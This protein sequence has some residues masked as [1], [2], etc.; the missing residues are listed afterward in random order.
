MQV[1]FGIQLV[2]LQRNGLGFKPVKPTWAGSITTRE[3]SKSRY[4]ALLS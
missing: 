4:K 2:G 1:G 3:E